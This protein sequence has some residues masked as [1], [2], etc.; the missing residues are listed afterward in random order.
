MMHGRKSI[1]KH[2][3]IQ[4]Y[5]CIPLHDQYFL[6]LAAAIRRRANVG[7][8]AAVFYRI[9]EPL[10][11]DKMYQLGKI[12]PVHFHYLLPIISHRGATE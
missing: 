4:I 9:S 6:W 1:K 7:R 12:I 8:L 3:I 11:R 5:T 10:G 2:Q